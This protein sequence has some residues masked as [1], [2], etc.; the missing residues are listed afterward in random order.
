MMSRFPETSPAEQASDRDSAKAQ[1]LFNEAQ[2]F[3]ATGDPGR[4]MATLLKIE[5]R[6]RKDP[7]EAARA[8]VASARVTR[9]VAMGRAGDLAQAIELF[10]SIASEFGTDVTPEVRAQVAGALV[11]RALALASLEKHAEAVEAFELVIRLFGDDRST[12]VRAEVAIA[13]ENEGNLLS[14]GGQPARAEEAWAEV[15][16]RYASDPEAGLRAR[17]ASALASTAQMLRD[18]GAPER[19]DR[20]LD[21]LARRF[22][23]ERHPQIVDEVTAA[24]V[25]PGTDL[26][27]AGHL[28]EAMAVFDAL[29]ER[30]RGD[31][32]LTLQTVVACA[33]YNKAI[34]HREAGRPD[35]AVAVLDEAL[36]ATRDATD[37][38]LRKQAAIS[39]FNKGVIMLKSGRADR[40]LA[41][42]D[43][44]VQHYGEDT[45]EMTRQRFAWSLYNRGRALVQLGRLDEAEASWRELARRLQADADSAEL[46]AKA[47]ADADAL[48]GMRARA[49]HAL[50]NTFDR[51]LTQE[52]LREEVKGTHDKSVIREYLRLQHEQLDEADRVAGVRHDEAVRMLWEHRE[53]G[54]PFALFLR[55][56]DLEA[57]LATSRRR[58]EEPVN[59]LGG[60]QR[61][62]P[63]EEALA[64]ALSQVVPVIGITNPA[65]TITDPK[66]LDQD[67]PMMPKLELSYD[68]WQQVVDELIRAARFIVV[69]LAVYSPGVAFELGLIRQHAKQESTVIILVPSSED[70]LEQGIRQFYEIPA[71]PSPALTSTSPQLS[72]FPRI[73]A[74]ADIPYGALSESLLFHDLLQN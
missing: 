65:N 60:G 21:D 63:V 30:Y 36:A 22:A 58:G 39:G 24:L 3:L 53:S 28:D 2:R 16:R 25:T 44:V 66:L 13:L 40:A 43:D 1:A 8:R 9:G 69:E 45:E 35:M 14:K 4:A 74:H 7:S 49:H 73:G 70:P 71:T 34:V 26:A 57:Y 17:A 52:L 50:S 33:R 62:S 20:V 64:N 6:W 31:G 56:F 38:P 55:N 11:N 29:I 27:Q 32:S 68:G 51:G 19:S 23:G 12:W 15:A 54:S 10:D 37:V 42:F 67:L 59:V 47:Q 41:A 5:R 72:D 18:V 46:V 48:A 61:P